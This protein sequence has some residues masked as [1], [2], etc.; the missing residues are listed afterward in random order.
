MSDSRVP[1]DEDLFQLNGL[2][3][4][5]GSGAEKLGR[6]DT[7]MPAPVRGFRSDG[8][9]PPAGHGSG[10]YFFREDLPPSDIR[11]RTAGMADWTKVRTRDPH[12]EVSVLNPGGV[13]G[14]GM[15]GTRALYR[16]AVTVTDF[17]SRM[18]GDQRDGLLPAQNDRLGPVRL[19]ASGE[20]APEEGGSGKGASGERGS[21][22]GA[23]GNGGSGKGAFRKGG[24]RKGTPAV[25]G[26]PFCRSEPTE[27]GGTPMTGM[28]GMPGTPAAAA[29]TGAVAQ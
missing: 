27:T 1:R 19:F 12:P 9:M 16:F 15:P 22:K 24:S 6:P 17:P 29:G 18:N 4:V 25:A 2:P 28:V 10:S 20:G 23:S 5:T 14:N 7:C 21:G 11:E 13:S 8:L 3:A 26:I